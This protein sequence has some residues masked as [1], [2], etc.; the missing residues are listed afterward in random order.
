MFFRKSLQGSNQFFRKASAD[1]PQFFRKAQTGLDNSRQITRNLSMQTNQVGSK[2]E[3]AGASI[4]KRDLGLSSL[5]EARDVVGGGLQ[6]VGGGARVL[7]K[8]AYGASQ[9]LGGDLIGAGRTF[10]SA[11]KDTKKVLQEGKDVLSSGTGLAGKVALAVAT[12][13]PMPL[14]I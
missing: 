7:G 13:N 3:R 8:S 5:N 6:V 4:K 1:A 10:S 2:L 14:I 9:V 11:K 12:K